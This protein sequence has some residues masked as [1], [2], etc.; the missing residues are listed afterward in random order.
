MNKP[1]NM[2]RR[3]TLRI[4]ILAFALA[5]TFLFLRSAASAGQ[6]NSCKESMDEC[7]KKKNA[8]E[9]DTKSWENL[10]RQFVSSI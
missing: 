1:T 9:A 8:G 6:N 7:C 10:S 5:G 2:R 3:N 4:A